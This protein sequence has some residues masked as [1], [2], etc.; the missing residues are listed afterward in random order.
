MRFAEPVDGVDGPVLDALRRQAFPAPRLHFTGQ[1][2]RGM[3]SRIQFKHRKF[4]LK[5]KQFSPVTCGHFP[6]DVRPNFSY[7]ITPRLKPLL[8]RRWCAPKK[9]N[10]ADIEQMR[11]M[12]V[13]D[14]A[15]RRRCF[16]CFGEPMNIDGGC[17][18][19]GIDIVQA[20]V[21]VSQCR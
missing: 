3:V 18:I 15:P 9:D 10:S 7:W 1:F 4:N 13:D 21:L 17:T 20:S 8:Q 14:P 11:K 16:P 12:T 6:F 2:L 5:F 19:L